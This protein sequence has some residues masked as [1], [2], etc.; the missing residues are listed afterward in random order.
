[1]TKNGLIDAVKKSFKGDNFSKWLTGNVLGTAFKNIH[2][3]IKK[4]NQFSYPDFETFTVRK[5]KARKGRKP[6]NG[7]EI[8]IGASKTVGFK[9]A[10]KLK[11]IL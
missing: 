8:Q 11:N 4:R 9:V 6:L 3:A 10:P 2:K 7:T 1:M 5:R